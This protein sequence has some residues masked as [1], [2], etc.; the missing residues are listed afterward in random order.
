[1]PQVPSPAPPQLAVQLPFEHVG[2]CPE[3]PVQ[4]PPFFPHAVLSVPATQLVPLQQP[5][6]HGIPPAHELVQTCE[7][8]QAS[9]AGQ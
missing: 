7:E 6:L 1:M 2:S 5:P 9:P 3:Q 8:L 4:A